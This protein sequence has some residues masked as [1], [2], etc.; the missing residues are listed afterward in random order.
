MGGTGRVGTWEQ[1][2]VGW[3]RDASPAWVYVRAGA[4]TLGPEATATATATATEVSFF[5][6]SPGE[7]W[8]PRCRDTHGRKEPNKSRDRMRRGPC[9]ETRAWTGLHCERTRAPSLRVHACTQWVQS[10]EGASSLGLASRH[11]RRCGCVRVV[12]RRHD[13]ALYNC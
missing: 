5:W 2:L 7:V 4:A 12:D 11:V 10:S 1:G 3:A 9:C 6:S 8:R 13:H